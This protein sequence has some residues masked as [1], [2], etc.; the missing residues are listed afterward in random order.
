MFR[1][2]NLDVWHQAVS[3]ADRIYKITADFP[4]DERFG[5]RSQMRRAS[6]SIASNIAEGSSRTSDKEYCRFVEIAYG[7]AMEVVT[8]L[9]IAHGQSFVGEES[10]QKALDHAEQL[11][12]ML[13]GLR[14]SLNRK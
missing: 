13:S 9:H 4:A 1:F 12:R 3:F 10:S 6:V 7:S 5:L 14:S 11:A 8:Q 2:E